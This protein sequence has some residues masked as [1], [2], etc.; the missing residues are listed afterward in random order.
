MKD[1]TCSCGGTFQDLGPEHIRIGKRKA[2]VD[3]KHV[4]AAFVAGHIFPDLVQT[5]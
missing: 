4:L 2:A 3:N 1:L 5:A